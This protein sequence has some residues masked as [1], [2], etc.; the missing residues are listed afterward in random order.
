MSFKTVGCRLNQSETAHMAAL[1]EAAGY[2]VVPFGTPCD[3]CV[4][5]TCAVTATA[6]HKCVRYARGV[7]RSNARALI[8]LAGCA[9][10]ATGQELLRKAGADM[11]VGQADKYRLPALIAARGR[12]P[13]SGMSDTAMPRAMPTMAPA[14]TLPRFSR[15]RALVKV[16]DGCD[17]CC[18]YCIVPRLRGPP[19]SRPLAE[20]VTEVRSLAEAGY[21]EVVLTGANLGTYSEQG[22]HLV[23]LLA[24]IEPIDGIDRV[25]LSSIELSTTERNVIDFMC[26][27]NKLCRSIHL[28][29]QSG[30]D[31]ILQRMRRRYDTAQFRA[32]VEY[33][34][35]KMP[36]L[37]IGTDI[38]VGFPGEDE[39][40]FQNTFSLVRELP[41]SNLHVFPYSPRPGTP[42]ASMPEQVRGQDKKRR[43]HL[44]MTLG[45]AKRAEFAEAFLGKPVTVLIESV[46]GKGRGQ[47]LTSEYLEARVAGPDV[48]RNE[49]VTFTPALAEDGL[50]S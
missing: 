5:H 36:M 33:A 20:V 27:S 48:S 28:P 15:T 49:I 31:G 11:A 7:R 47:G 23:D 29:M 13:A 16:Q 39:Q 9:V 40:A 21:R 2:V 3:V 41:L 38:L 25:R 12:A 18:A 50:L 37:G 6:E 42:A 43:C 14:P 32:F 35:G 46:D 44:L 19:R 26:H 45:S 22:R 1:F 34:V 8:V 17:F 4:V 30:D 24:A 10:E